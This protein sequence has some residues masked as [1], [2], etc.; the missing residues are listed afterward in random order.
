MEPNNSLTDWPVPFVPV[1]DGYPGVGDALD[2]LPMLVTTAW[3]ALPPK[4]DPRSCKDIRGRLHDYQGILAVAGLSRREIL[5]EAFEQRDR[6]I[7]FC[8]HGRA[9]IMVVPQYA[10]PDRPQDQ[11]ED[12]ERAMEMHTLYRQA[13]FP[14]VVMTIPADPRCRQGEYLAF[15]AREQVTAVAI[16][17]RTDQGALEPFHLGGLQRIA[18]ALRPG[19]AV[20]V[21]GVG[22]VIGMAQV[23]KLLPGR[24]VVLASK[25]PYFSAIYQQL[26]PHDARAPGRMDR[27]AVFAHNVAWMNE[28]ADKVRNPKPSIPPMM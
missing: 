16:E 6:V 17:M 4:R 13:G 2:A 28:L 27:G 26:M 14:L 11:H 1:I 12:I 22:A 21:F 19:V 23:A 7:D 24:R 3:T 10:S 18:A 25:V 15:C 9:D 8:E 20:M 5:L